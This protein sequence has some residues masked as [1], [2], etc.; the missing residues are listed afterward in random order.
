MVCHGAIG[1]QLALDALGARICGRYC[2]SD[3]WP[4]QRIGL[5]PSARHARA[6]SAP[7]AVGATAP[8]ALAGPWADQ[9]H[10]M[11]T[12]SARRT[13]ARLL[14][15]DHELHLG[16]H[17]A[18]RAAV[19]RWSNRQREASTC[20]AETESMPLSVAPQTYRLRPGFTFDRAR[21]SSLL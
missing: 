5:Y 10:I 1:H 12:C 13:E 19:A 3:Y 2:G 9:R 14:P 17:G 21:F 20:C 16:L 8:W 4:F 6:A 15:L 7:I 11:T 18:P